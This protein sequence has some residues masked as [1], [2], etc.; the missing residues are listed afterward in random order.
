MSKWRTPVFWRRRGLIAC[1]LFPL[2]LL[3]RCLVAVRRSAYRYGLIESWRSPVPILVVGN[4][5]AGGAG[6]TPLVIAL[7]ELLTARGLNVGIAMRSYGADQQQPAMLV[8]GNSAPQSTGDEAVMVRRRTGA[9]V[10]VAAKRGEAVK[11][12]LSQQMFQLIVCDDGLQHYALQRDLE[13]AV[14]DSHFGLGNGF[15]LPAGPLRESPARLAQVDLLVYSGA[16]RKAPGYELEV[17]GVVNLLQPGVETTLDKLKATKVHAVAAI[18]YP[19]RFFRTLRANGLQLLEHAFPD[20]HPYRS[21]D[22]NFADDLPILMTEKDK[23]KC[24]A[25]ASENMWY[26]KVSAIIDNEIKQQVNALV[27]ITIH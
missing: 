2:S 8:T 26:L 11:L 22:L 20:H 19:D 21:E 15:F 13:I 7:V 3:F 24:E 5:T 17:E 12:L 18:A 10:A 9:T 1:L 4:I 23:V 16:D 25:F 6:K 27:D 14:V